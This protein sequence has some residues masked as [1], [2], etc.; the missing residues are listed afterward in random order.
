MKNDNKWEYGGIV[1]HCKF[2]NPSAYKK[3]KKPC[4]ALVTPHDPKSGKL[5]TKRQLY[6]TDSDEPVNYCVRGASPEDIRSRILPHTGQ[7]LTA[8]MQE[9]GL[10]SEIRANH[11]EHDLAELGRAFEEPFFSHHV[12]RDHWCESTVHT[13]KG[14]Y[15]VLMDEL[16]GIT[17]ES[18]DAEKY[19]ELQLKICINALQ[20]SE[21][22]KPNFQY[23]DKPSSSGKTRI[24]LFYLLIWDL[25]LIEGINIPVTPFPYKGKMSRSEELLIRTDKARY[26]PA[27]DILKLFSNPKV[28]EQGLLMADCGL[29]ISETAGLLW[30]SLHAVEGSQGMLYY[31]S[32]SGQITP[33]VGI[34]TE[35]TKT[36]V[37]YRTVPVSKPLGEHLFHQKQNWTEKYG[38]ISMC[39]MCSNP[40]N[41][42]LSDDAKNTG[43]YM[44]NIA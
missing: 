40:K 19:K 32:V 17:A 23:G 7:Y 10:L 20:K 6:G 9:A 21:E 13:Y 35:I 41:G 5:L 36:D 27:C 37:A 1:F 33:T 28:A 14:Q 29:R 22:N 8:K 16:E 15:K 42:R 11:A 34:R 12:P 26:Y 31:L 24:N 30:A 3:S 44:K 4:R 2:S 38:D 39:L 25:K 18:L 43:K